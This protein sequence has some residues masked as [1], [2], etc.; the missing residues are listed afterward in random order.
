MTFPAYPEYKDSDV[1]WLGE[2]PAHWEVKAL[3]FCASWNDEV[4]P[5]SMPPEETIHYVEIS[6]V[7]VGK[8]ILRTQKMSFNDAPSRARRIVREGD[9]VVSTVRTYLKAIARISGLPKDTVV[10]TGFAVVRP[11]SEQVSSLFLGYLLQSDGFVSELIASSVGVSYPAI[12]AS[13][14]VG[15]PVALPPHE[16][17]A[18]IGLFLDHET[19]RIDAL[20]EEQQ[21]LIE[22]LKEKRQA[23]ISHAVT[24]GLDPDVPMKDSGV[25]WLGEVPAHSDMAKFKYAIAE[26]EQGWS[27]QCDNE[28]V[29]SID[30]WGV[31]KV[32]CVNHGV[33][34]P[35]ENKRLPDEL[36]A[37]P[38]L[39]VR[40]D[41]LLVSRA[42]TRELVGSA[43]QVP[44]D[45][46]N[47]MA[48]DKL[49]IVRLHYKICR[50]RF[51]AAYLGDHRVRHQI[52]LEATGASSSM[53]NIGQAAIR[54]LCVPLP[55]EVEQDRIVE[56]LDKREAGFEALERETAFHIQL[57]NERRSALI[58][59]AVTGKIDVRD[60]TPPASSAEPDHEAEGAVT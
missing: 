24:K 27:P 46:P 17:Q 19:A 37:R 33:F 55:P 16:E 11:Q 32:G 50:P 54:E 2:V 14:L 12:N 5:E 56:E 8:G 42:N 22:L 44:A 10:S 60:W 30:E 15:F 38:E 41:D 26:F 40:E 45:Q 53:L 28:P 34:D 52:E 48:S 20:I 21:R 57:L 4:L 51:A 36:E 35:A 25:E 13:D 47:L 31:L 9:V 6:D 39:T 18:T 3:K 29:G 1:E 58:S 7:E 43:A 49:F 23:V 59:A